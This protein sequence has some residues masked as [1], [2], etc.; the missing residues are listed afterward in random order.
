[1]KNIKANQMNNAFQSGLKNR[2]V[3]LKQDEKINERINMSN[4]NEQDD[5]RLEESNMNIL[6]LNP[7]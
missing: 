2:F 6:Y 7:Q 3:Y 5:K 4:N 1:M